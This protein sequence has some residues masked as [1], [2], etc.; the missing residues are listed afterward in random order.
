MPDQM[1]IRTAIIE[2]AAALK[3]SEGMRLD[4]A[5]AHAIRAFLRT[6]GRR[7]GQAMP[8]DE[9]AAAVERITVEAGWVTE[10]GAS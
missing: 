1:L 5:A 6:I 8:A 4:C 10:E 9:L 7:P 2:A 3:L